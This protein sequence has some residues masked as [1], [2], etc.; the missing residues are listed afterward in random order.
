MRTLKCL[1]LNCTCFRRRQSSAKGTSLCN[2]NNQTMAAS[3]NPNDKMY[4][5][6]QKKQPKRNCET[7]DPLLDEFKHHKE[8]IINNRINKDLFQN[9]KESI[10]SLTMLT[11]G[12]TKHIAKIREQQ[13]HAKRL[14]SDLENHFLKVNTS[15]KDKK[16][17]TPSP[18][19]HE[20][21]SSRVDTPANIVL[22]HSDS[23]AMNEA[24]SPNSLPSIFKDIQSPS[25]KES[26]V[27]HVAKTNH[28]KKVAR[29][30]SKE[31]SVKAEDLFPM[32]TEDLGM[33]HVQ[34]NATRNDSSKK[35]TN[36]IGKTEARQRVL[37]R[38][39]AL[40]TFQDKY[41]VDP[42]QGLSATGLFTN[43]SLNTANKVMENI[44]KSRQK[45]ELNKK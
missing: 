40:E 18:Y 30:K 3:D 36:L 26:E 14:W 32:V 38:L 22:T 42:S 28:I 5:I 39:V 41:I 37:R 2:G 19:P 21:R 43:G 24:S 6:R 13:T 34:L 7:R 4:V 33:P 25:Q 20:S 29:K 31:K 12:L 35:K 27:F 9:M 8:K 17:G 45:R 16:Q 1:F 10:L 44:Q 11:N 23:V 15:I